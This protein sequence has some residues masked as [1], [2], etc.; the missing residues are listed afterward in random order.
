[1]TTY[2]V[3]APWTYDRRYESGDYV[4]LSREQFMYF[5]SIMPGLLIEDEPAPAKA[6]K[7]K[8][9]DGEVDA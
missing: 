8:T 5:E 4:T 3:T 1:M 9:G 6:T 2:R 7:R